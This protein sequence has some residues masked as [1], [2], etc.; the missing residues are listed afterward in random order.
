MISRQHDQIN[1]LSLC[2]IHNLVGRTAAQDCVGCNSPAKVLIGKILE[3]CGALR[4]DIEKVFIQ[5]LVEGVACKPKRIG[6]YHV[7]RVQGGMEAIGPG[8]HMLRCQH[9]ASR[10]IDR[11]KDVTY[12]SCHTRTPDSNFSGYN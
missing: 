3:V 9:R 7:Q 1:V 5:M 4:Y 12:F 2:E 10:Q 11:K 8:L 6:L